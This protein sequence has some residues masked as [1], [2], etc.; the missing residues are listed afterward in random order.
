MNIGCGQTAGI[1]VASPYLVKRFIFYFIYLSAVEETLM[2]LAEK[3][4]A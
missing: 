2:V 1:F 3:I 4:T